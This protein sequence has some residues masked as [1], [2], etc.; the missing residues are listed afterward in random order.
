M[1]GLLEDSCRNKTGVDSPREYGKG[2]TTCGDM[3]FRGFLCN[4]TGSES[5]REYSKADTTNGERPFR[6]F[7]TK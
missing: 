5:L 4:K 6:A 1:I 2:D 7:L 3:P